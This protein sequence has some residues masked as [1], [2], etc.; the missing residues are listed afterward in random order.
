M[1]IEHSINNRAI[2]HIFSV[3]LICRQNFVI[4]DQKEAAKDQF[5]TCTLKS[6]AENS[7]R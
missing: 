2:I 6:L 3:M 5:Q 1:K 4:I 7:E